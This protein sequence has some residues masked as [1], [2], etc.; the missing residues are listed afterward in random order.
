MFTA[1]PIA[2]TA[3]AGLMVAQAAMADEGA[4]TSRPD[5]CKADYAIQEL[6]DVTFLD[7]LSVGDH[8]IHC[9]WEP[10]IDLSKRRPAKQLRKAECMDGASNWSVEVV[11]KRAP[12]DAVTLTSADTRLPRKTYSPCPKGYDR[13]TGASER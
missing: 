2:F 1:K 10:A 8:Y 3:L 6:E 4:F 11:F 7:A 13:P 12:G 5:L 9:N